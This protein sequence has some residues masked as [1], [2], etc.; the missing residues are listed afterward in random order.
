MPDVRIVQ[1]PVDTFDALSRGALAG[2]NETS[3]VPLSEYLASPEN[4]SVWSR[5]YR[6]VLAE[7]ADGAWVTGAIWDMEEQVTVGRAGYHSAP[8]DGTLEIGYAVDPAFRRRGYARAALQELLERA[9]QEPG[10]R[11][12]RLT[13]APGNVASMS[14]AGQFPFRT[15]GEQW[16]DEDGLEIILEMDV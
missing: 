12:V 16:D 6:Q 3:P 13:I 15:V 9:A 14:L 2:A 10:V 1:L 11:T 4:T 8:V 5:R 7:P